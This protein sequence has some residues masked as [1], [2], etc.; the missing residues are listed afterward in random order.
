MAKFA[1][2]NRIPVRVEGDPNTIWVVDKLN[3]GMRQRILSAMAQISA[4]V[5]LKSGLQPQMTFDVGAYNIAVAQNAIVG[6]DGPDFEGEDVTPENIA[7]LDFDDPLVRAA[8]QAAGQ[9]ARNSTDT[10]DPNS[11]TPVIETG[12]NT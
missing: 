5:G 8:L 9:R 10:T 4:E 1:G 2:R 7:A 3:Y 6:W 12:A 11:G